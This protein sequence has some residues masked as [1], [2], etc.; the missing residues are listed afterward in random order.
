VR[1]SQLDQLR[2]RAIAAW[3]LGTLSMAEWRPYV[4]CRLRRAGWRNGELFEPAALG[5]LH[6]RSGGVPRRINLLCS[7]LL[8]TAALERRHRVD[9]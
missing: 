3:H 9:A 7:R 2:G 1:S 8:L 6:A 4:D 5:R